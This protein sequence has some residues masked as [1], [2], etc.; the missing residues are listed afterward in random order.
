MNETGGPHILH[1]AD[2]LD[3]VSIPFVDAMFISK[4]ILLEDIVKQPRAQAAQRM[5]QARRWLHEGMGR[6]VPS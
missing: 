5:E 1:A 6:G 4:A 2:V 3:L